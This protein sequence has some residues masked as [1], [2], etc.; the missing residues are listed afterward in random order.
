MHNLNSEPMTCC[1]IFFLKLGCP[2]FFSGAAEGDYS[3]QK[4]SGHPEDGEI[5]ALQTQVPEDEEMHC[6]SSNCN[7]GI[8]G[9]ETLLCGLLIYNSSD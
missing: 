5:M 1:Y 4:D 9:K 7:E 8:H 3:Y 6:S 2:R